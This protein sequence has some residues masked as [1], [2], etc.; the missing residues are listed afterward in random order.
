M[1]TSRWRIVA[2]L[3]PGLL[4]GIAFS[5]Y[6]GSIPQPLSYHQFADQRSLLSIPHVGDVLTN[7]PFLAVGWWG[8]WFLSQSRLS[9][10]SFVDNSERRAFVG[11]F[12][13]IFLTGFG[14]GWYH[15]DPDNYSLVW[16]RLPMAL[17]FMSIFAAMI[18]ERIG[19]SA[20]IALLGPLVLAGALSVL[21]WIWTEH[22][23]QG[24]LRWYLFVQ[25][26]PMLTILLMLLLLPT[27]YSRGNDYW[28][29]LA[30]YAAAKV[31]EIYDHQIFE[32][33]QG[34]ASGHNLKHV[35]AALSGVWVLRMLWLRQPRLP[36]S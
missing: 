8:L 5:L 10:K 34:I 12:L 20:G 36:A 24:D 23:G 13:G 28:G 9:E 17:A 19:R 32:F 3:I 26:Y 18:S 6:S 30:F 1:K 27:P 4:A 22:E 16:D 15:L 11:L 14:S 29:L 7:V 31:T 25:F 21:W 2:T 35:L 33:T